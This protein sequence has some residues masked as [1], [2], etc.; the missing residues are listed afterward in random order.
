LQDVAS[1]LATTDIPVGQITTAR[2]IVQGALMVPVILLMGLNWRVSGRMVKF[3]AQRAFF[4][5]LSNYFFV[6][7]VAVMP[8]ADALTIAF[9]LPFILLWFGKTLFK[10]EIGPHRIWA[11]L[12]GFSGALLVIQPS[13][14][15]FGLVALF[16]LGTAFSFAAYILTTRKMA[17]YMHPVTMQLHTSIMGIVMCLPVMLWADDTG[18]KEF[19]PLMPQGLNWLWLFGVGFW[20]AISHM[21]MTYALKFAPSTTLAPLHY[22]EIVA[23]V[24]LG[25]LVFGDFPNRMTWSGIAVII[26]SGLYIIHRER[27][28]QRRS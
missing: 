23:A 2:F 15:A 13:L 19:D 5:I 20:A 16:P 24:A 4:L 12:V 6:M 3:L 10:D 26:A 18:W 17:G 27:L 1:K 7:A 28:A 9:I 21:S 11:S 14:N 22:F 25:Y 8:I